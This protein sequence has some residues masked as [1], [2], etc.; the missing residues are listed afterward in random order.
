[1]TRQERALTHFQTGFNCAQSVLL[2]FACELG[3]SEES[4]SRLAQAFGG[5]MARTGQ[6]CGAVTGAMLVLGLKHGKVKPEDDAA[7]EKTYAL[8]REFFSL[9]QAKNGSLL[10]WQLLGID[11]S[12]PGGHELANSKGLFQTVCPQLIRSSIDILEELL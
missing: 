6:T 2:A 3:L 12:S 7:R 1:M 11:L 5:G 8:T 9:F 4:A 10:C